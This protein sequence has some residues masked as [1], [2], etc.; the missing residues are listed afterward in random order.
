MK[1]DALTELSDVGQTLDGWLLQLLDLFLGQAARDD[2]TLSAQGLV[3]LAAVL[4]LPTGS[5]LADMVLLLGTRTSWRS[6]FLVALARGAV[7][8]SSGGF[9]WRAQSGQQFHG[10]GEDIGEVEG[11]WGHAVLAG[12][13]LRRLGRRDEGLRAVVLVS[14]GGGSQRSLA[15]VAGAAR[16]HWRGHHG[17]VQMQALIGRRHAV[18]VQE[19]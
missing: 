2:A 15:Q 7:V 13:A 16:V 17:H 19:S 6:V 3:V 8:L 9:G 4:A 14:W 10:I 18:S 12:T 1:F 11:A 5:S